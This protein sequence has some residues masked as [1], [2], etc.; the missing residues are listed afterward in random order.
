MQPEIIPKNGLTDFNVKE[1]SAIFWKRSR[2]TTLVIKDQLTD[3]ARTLLS[4]NET[5]MRKSF[6]L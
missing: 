4:V 5:I 6:S 2:S 1:L 3:I